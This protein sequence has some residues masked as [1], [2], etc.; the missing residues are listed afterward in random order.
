MFN[1]QN[2]R[3]VV[4]V[5]YIVASVAKSV[6]VTKIDTIVSVDVFSYP[7][8]VSATFRWNFNGEAKRLVLGKNSKIS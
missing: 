7:K 6:A 5:V 1:N 8:H 3:S 2:F 4:F